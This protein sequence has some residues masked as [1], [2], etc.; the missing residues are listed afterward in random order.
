MDGSTSPFLM[1]TLLCSQVKAVTC[2]RVTSS[3]FIISQQN[4]LSCQFLMIPTLTS[5]F[6]CVVFYA[7]HIWSQFDYT[8]TRI[9]GNN[10]YKE[11]QQQQ[12]IT[13]NLPSGQIEK[14]SVS[15]SLVHGG[16]NFA[17]WLTS[18]YLN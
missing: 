17:F 2:F 8:Y 1:M 15:L 16:F 12:D 13:V 5:I 4:F 3:T 7:V 11:M 14:I 6:F 10:I 18:F 9:A